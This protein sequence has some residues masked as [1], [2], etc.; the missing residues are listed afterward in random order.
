MKKCFIAKRILVIAVVT[1]AGMTVHSVA[2]QMVSSQSAAPQPALSQPS[3][4]R[5]VWAHEL[6]TFKERYKMW[7]KMR[8]ARSP[9]ERM[10]L[11]V[12]KYTELEKRAANRGLV[13]V[14]HG[15]MM[16]A[17]DSRRWSQS[18]SPMTEHASSQHGVLRLAPSPGR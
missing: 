4:T 7:R 9:D 6:M 16:M 11:W 8:E 1:A 5:G 15:P 14:D 10:A 13:L 12:K 17:P 18:W 2:A 3:P